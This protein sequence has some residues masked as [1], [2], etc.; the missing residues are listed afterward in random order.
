MRGPGPRRSSPCR[1]PTWPRWRG[2]KAEKSREKPRFATTWAFL[3]IYR[4]LWAFDAL[5]AGKHGLFWARPL[6]QPKAASGEPLR[7]NVAHRA[8][9]GRR[10]AE[11]QQGEHT[12]TRA[13][14]RAQINGGSPCQTAPAPRTRGARRWTARNGTAPKIKNNKRTMSS[15]ARC[16]FSTALSGGFPRSRWCRGSC[17]R[18]SI[19]T[20]RAGGSGRR[21][22]SRG[23]SGRGRS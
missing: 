12:P 10:S 4:L 5:S 18:W 23:A 22:G 14:F 6:P 17:R 21:A 7:S 1:A 11:F 2:A 8:E 9:C 20:P 15:R 19:A 13:A 16:A 3:G